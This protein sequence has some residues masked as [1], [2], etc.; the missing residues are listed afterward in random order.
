MICTQCF[1]KEAFKKIE[2]IEDGEPKFITLCV[3]CL[4]IRNKKEAFRELTNR[5]ARNKT[6]PAKQEEKKEEE[7][8]ICS[9][10][11]FSEK[12][13]KESG[14][15]GCEECY[16]QFISLNEIIDV[17]QGKGVIHKGKRI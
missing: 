17:Y 2:I 5:P 13:F 15:L 6:E 16:K 1:V 9:F 14:F 7:D 12:D 10:C 4:N 8:H 11:G 3:D